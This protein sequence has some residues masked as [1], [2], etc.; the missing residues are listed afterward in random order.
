MKWVMA[1]LLLSTSAYGGTTAVHC[2]ADE[3]TVVSQGNLSE[4]EAWSAW[5]ILSC[6]GEKPTLWL[7]GDKEPKALYTTSKSKLEALGFI[8]G[9]RPGRKLED[10]GITWRISPGTYSRD[11]PI[12]LL[13]EGKN[14]LVFIDVNGEPFRVLGRAKASCGRQIDIDPGENAIVV[15]PENQTTVPSSNRTPGR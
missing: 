12:W 7:F 10:I 11:V 1:G 14:T 6:P 2:E 3:D 13:R 15:T 8:D 4:R 9:V 5:K